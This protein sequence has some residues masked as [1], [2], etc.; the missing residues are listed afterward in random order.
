[1]FWYRYADILIDKL[2]KKK[3]TIHN[4]FRHQNATTNLRGN[5]LVL[6]IRQFFNAPAK[7]SMHTR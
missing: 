1:M 4:I 6:Y 5:N 3:I 7:T 2:Q